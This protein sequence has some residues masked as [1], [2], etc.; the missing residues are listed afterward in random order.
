MVEPI[1]PA[2]GLK[3]R[4]VGPVGTVNVKEFVEP[5]QLAEGL[6]PVTTTGPVV[7][8]AGSITPTADGVQFELCTGVPL[9]VTEELPDICEPKFVPATTTNEPA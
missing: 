7:T 1:G 5:H 4:I 3:P 8:P 6:Q 9:K 2:T